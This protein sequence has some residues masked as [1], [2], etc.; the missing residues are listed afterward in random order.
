MVHGQGVKS[1]DGGFIGVGFCLEQS[2]LTCSRQFPCSE[3]IEIIMAT[4]DKFITSHHIT[5]HH[6]EQS[7]ENKLLVRSLR[8]SVRQIKPQSSNEIS[9]R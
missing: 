9:L 1:W 5:S 4:F 6:F 7:L 3:N 8:S 2:D